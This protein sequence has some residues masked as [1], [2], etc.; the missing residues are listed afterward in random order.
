MRA[1]IRM[2]LGMQ[3]IRDILGRFQAEIKTLGI[4]EHPHY[5]LLTNT[6]AFHQCP[7]T[8]LEAKFKSFIYL[9]DK[10]QGST[11]F[12]LCCGYCWLRLPRF[13]T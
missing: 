2:P 6:P 1:Q 7:E 8:P 3:S 4:R 10:C 12:L 5:V 13:T 11:A 9:V